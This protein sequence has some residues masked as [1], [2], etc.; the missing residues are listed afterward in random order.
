MMRNARNNT[1]KRFADNAGPDQGIR[2]H[3]TESIDIVIYVD[4]QKMFRSNS[5]DAHA[6]ADLRFSQMAEGPFYQ[7]ASQHIV[8]HNS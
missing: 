5:T 6:Q 7:G 3:L 2:C 4:G 8:L 1:L